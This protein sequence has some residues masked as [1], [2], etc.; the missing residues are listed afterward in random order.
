MGQA[1]IGYKN[2]RDENENKIIAPDQY[3]KHVT[4]AFKMMATGKYMQQEIRKKLIKDGF[5]CGKNAFSKMLKNPV[6]NGKIQIK[7]YKED[8]ETWYKFQQV[9]N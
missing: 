8:G 6:Y 7:A 2:T 4:K 5:T 9:L 3:A 1:P